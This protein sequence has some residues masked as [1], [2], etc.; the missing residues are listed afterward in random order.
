[1]DTV[2]VRA[3]SLSRWLPRRIDTHAVSAWSLC[4]ALVVYLGLDGGGYALPVHGDVG[5]CV[6]W[7][8]V[9][10]A[11][12]G[13]LPVARLSRTGIAGISLFTGFA[14]WTALGITWSIS[15]G[16]SFQ[17]LTLVDSYLGILV[18]GLAIHRERAHAVRHTVGAV[19]TS[20]VALALIALIARMW[21]QLIPSSRGL[22]QFASNTA[23][24]QWPLNYWNGLA[25]LMALGL[26]L[27]LTL[28][29]SA[30]TLR[31]QAA[32]AAGI[33]IL[34]V[35]GALTLSRG[36]IISAAAALIVFFAFAPDRIPKLATGA[37]A[38]IGSAILVAGAFHRHAIQKG[39]VGSV[40]HHQAASFAVVVI[41]V[42]IGVAVAQAAVGLLV[43]HATPPRILTISIGQ[44]R[45][46]LAIGVVIVIAV[47]LALHAPGHLNHLWNDFKSPQGVAN[48][49]SA[50]R[51]TGTSGEGRYQYWV[52]AIDATKSHPFI[53]SGPG[54]FQL[55]WLPR[56]T[57]YSYVTN[58]HS[59][60]VETYAELGIIGLALLVGFFLLALA[61]CIRTVLRTEGPERT[62]AAGITAMLVAFLLFAGFDWLWQLPVIPAAVLLLIAA[63]LAPER[64]STAV[65][66]IRRS[67]R[68]I[69]GGRVVSIAAVALGLA[70][71][72]AIAYP[73]AT[74]NQLTASQSAFNAGNL[75]TALIDARKAVNLE[76]G[77]APAQIQLALVL[78]QDHAIPAAIAAAEHAVHA[79]SQNWSN[80]LTL[81]RLEAEGGHARASVA[82]YRQARKLNPE[83]PIFLSS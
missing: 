82:D 32:A 31:A 68:W 48:P 78:E 77:S 70:S 26:P 58:A 20:I 33:P 64:A 57:I 35:C 73:L 25:A 10:C 46:L 36:G 45:V 38:A 30:R 13:L 74:N 81:S 83:S 40:E 14:A 56:A 52:A 22:S 53:G 28:A 21:P 54:T 67:L 55:L 27:L 65:G 76:P 61:A 49:T 75:T 2:A 47:A 19:A 8:V 79:E 43:R 34:V 72:V 1:M 71:L 23:R 42:C 69:P 41:L 51:L 4:V 62:R 16:R 11:A 29:T 12:W 9:L 63:V 17:D 6:W 44:A 15:S 7:I 50:D 24:L 80:W 66:A 39:L 18:L 5:I 37:L 60:Y 3:V 59:L